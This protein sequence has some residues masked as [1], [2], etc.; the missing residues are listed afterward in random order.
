MLDL[1]S[2]FTVQQ[3]L[4]RDNYK[5]R[6]NQSE[7]VGL[8]EFFYALLQGY[9]AV[10]LRADVQLGALGASRSRSRGSSSGG[11]SRSS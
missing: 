6:L 2:Q 9:D 11:R 5:R 10:H 7:P 1:A 4:A 3:F 8:H